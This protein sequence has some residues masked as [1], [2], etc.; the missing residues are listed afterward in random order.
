[1]RLWH[2]L[3]C[4]VA[5]VLSGVAQAQYLVPG[6]NPVHPRLPMPPAPGGNPAQP[7]APQ[8]PAPG[9]S[10]ASRPAW[11]GG[12]G[13]SPAFRQS[14]QPG[15]P[16]GGPGGQRFAPFWYYPPALYRFGGVSRS[17]DLTGNQVGL[18]NQLTDDL[19]DRYSGAYDQLESLPAAQR[20]VSRELVNQQYMRDWMNAAS[21]VLSTDQLVRYQQIE[22]QR[23]GITALADPAVQNWLN[24]SQQQRTDLP[25]ALVWGLQQRDD[26]RR[27]AAT[28]PAAARDRYRDYRQQAQDMLNRFLTPDQQTTWRQLTGQ[29]YDVEP[30]FTTTEP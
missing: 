17:L 13:A 1:M 6:T 5:L 12:P 19:R 9:G 21:T 25:T 11:P 23:G 28:D 26:I 30:A 20:L 7:R 8:P 2:I 29:T 14:G 3:G 4:G 16:I 18:L 24:L 27:L 10:P 22:L 15:A